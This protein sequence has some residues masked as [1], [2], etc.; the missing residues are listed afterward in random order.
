ML[1]MLTSNI[2][3]YINRI[4]A[5]DNAYKAAQKHMREVI[6][7]NANVEIE[8]NLWLMYDVLCDRSITINQVKKDLMQKKVML[9]QEKK[10]CSERGRHCFEVLHMIKKGET[11]YARLVYL[12]GF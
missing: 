3:Y 9:E 10:R 11:S 12:Q 5:T 2:T 6:D 8:G 1:M 7:C 4:N